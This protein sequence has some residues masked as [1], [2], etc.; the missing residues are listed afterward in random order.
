MTQVSVSKIHVFALHEPPTIHA[1]Y[2]CVYYLGSVMHSSIMN[3][4]VLVPQVK[5]WEKSWN[6]DVF[7][8]SVSSVVSTAV[9]MSLKYF[10]LS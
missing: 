1:A 10:T 5:V 9:K 6:G 7:L 2:L 3:D 4:S 8:P